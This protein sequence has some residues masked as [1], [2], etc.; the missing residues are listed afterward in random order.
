MNPHDKSNGRQVHVLNSESSIYCPQYACESGYELG[1]T[2][3]ST[4]VLLPPTLPT[5]H[6]VFPEQAQFLVTHQSM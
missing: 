2:P 5:S 3:V 6:A 1:F 4:L